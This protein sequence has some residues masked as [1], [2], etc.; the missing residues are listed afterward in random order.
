LIEEATVL[1]RAQMLA[2]TQEPQAS[3][4]DDP[5]DD[6]NEGGTRR[7]LFDGDE[8]NEISPDDE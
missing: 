3:T 6:P 8:I 2:K 7:R 4:T 5:D 1:A